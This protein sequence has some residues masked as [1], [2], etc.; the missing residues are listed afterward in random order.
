[1]WYK[2]L[3]LGKIVFVQ[4]FE[5]QSYLFSNLFFINCVE[6]NVLGIYCDVRA[7]SCGCL[8]LVTTETS[9]P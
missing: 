2:G 7:E 8:S 3:C 5:G 1:M 4:C 6:S 9:G